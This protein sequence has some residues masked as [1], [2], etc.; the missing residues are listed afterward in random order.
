M[1]RVQ[2]KEGVM[3]YNMTLYFGTFPVIA[4]ILPLLCLI[5]IQLLKEKRDERERA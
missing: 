1:R 3:L 5:I 4:A 2:L